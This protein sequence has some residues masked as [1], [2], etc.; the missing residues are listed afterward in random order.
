M[1]CDSHGSG[2]DLAA[3]APTS[4]RAKQERERGEGVRLRRGR[5]AEARGKKWWGS[6]ARRRFC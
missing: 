4:E 6:R 2:G 3:R 1:E 5:I